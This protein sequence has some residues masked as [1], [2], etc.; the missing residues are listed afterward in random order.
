MGRRKPRWFVQWTDW[1]GDRWTVNGF[2]TQEAAALFVSGKATGLDVLTWR[3]G[4]DEQL[5]TS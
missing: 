2:R 1:H 3:I 4:T 5:H